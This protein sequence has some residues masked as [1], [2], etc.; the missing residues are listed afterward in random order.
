MNNKNQINN[1]L[2]E[3][4]FEVF[5]GSSNS[6]TAILFLHGYPS[7]LGDKNADI[8]MEV[9]QK[10]N[11]DCFLIHYPGLGK[12]HGEFSFSKS[13]KAVHE[14]C[15]HLRKLGYDEIHFVGHSWGG[16]LALNSAM[17]WTR[18][19]KVILMSPFLQIPEGSELQAL[20]SAVYSE[21]KEFLVPKSETEVLQDLQELRKSCSQENI[22]KNIKMTSNEI[23]LIQ[24]L[25]DEECSPQIAKEFVSKINNQKIKYLE[26]QT[27]HSFSQNRAQLIEM[28]CNAFL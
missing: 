5:K 24:A 22:I 6:N 18:K 25:H 19:S 13:L 4:Y 21:T 11:L 26:L 15:G 3:T 28:L 14:F 12:S 1:Y 27:D 23:T 7:D 9:T 10:T 16:F 20:V 17:L 2:N 8:A